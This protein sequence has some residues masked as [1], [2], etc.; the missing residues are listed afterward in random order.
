M[1]TQWD[2]F[3]V[4]GSEMRCHV[5]IPDGKRPFPAV[6]V[7]M[8]APG[9]DGFIQGIDA[10][11]AESGFAAI[12]P[13]VYHRQPP[14]KENPLEKMGKL[15]DDE[16]ARDLKAAMAHLRDTPGVDG[17]RCAVIGFCMGGRLSYLFA[18]HDEALR[19]AVVFYGG[20]IMV[21]WGDGPAPFERT[22]RIACPVLGLFGN[23][24]QNPSPDDV[25]KID[26]EM[27]RLGRAHEFHGYDG[28]GHAFLNQ[29]RPSYREE[30]AT[31]AWGRCVAWL[32]RHLA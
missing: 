20:N 16:V 10:R 1:S 27:T 18:S 3:A 13:D 8:H 14:G 7:C 32:H 26:A 5:A 29:K 17:G 24:D 4:D 2:T 9:V 11:L 22:E 25:A 6:L 23:E 21:P 19:A 15:R 30:A 28:A 31:D 12:A